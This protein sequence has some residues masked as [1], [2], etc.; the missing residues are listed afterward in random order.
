MIQELKKKKL[1]TTD[2]EIEHHQ[3][4][5]STTICKLFSI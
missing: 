4:R 5:R 1:Y 3:N 2:T